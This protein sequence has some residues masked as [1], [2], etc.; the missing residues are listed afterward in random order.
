MLKKLL[1]LLFVFLSLIAFCQDESDGMKESKYFIRPEIE[2]IR[3]YAAYLNFGYQVLPNYSIGAGLGYSM[4]FKGSVYDIK[5][6]E[7]MPI[8]LNNR[9]YLTNSEL[10]LFFDIRVGYIF[11]IFSG[12]HESRK[13]EFF[14]VANFY[15]SAC[16]GLN[17]KKWDFGFNMVFYEIAPYNSRNLTHIIPCLKVGYNIPL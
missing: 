6:S 16:L 7:I 10:R 9:F 4:D 17:Y 12:Y 5:Y 8:T 11:G 14:K 2:V 15:G 13:L 3:N 1:F